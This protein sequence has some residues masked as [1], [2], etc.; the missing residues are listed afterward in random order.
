MS[1]LDEQTDLARV[2]DGLRNEFRRRLGMLRTQLTDQIE[3][4]GKAAEQR[5]RELDA[6]LDASDVRLG[7]LRGARQAIA[8]LSGEI[9]LIEG[10][11]RLEHGVVPIELDEIS[12]VLEPMVAMV[13]EAEDIRA[14]ILDDESRAALDE[15]ITAYEELER[16]AEETRTRALE[17]SRA[18]ACERAGGRAFRRAAAAYRRERERLRAQTEELRTT[19]AGCE[20]ARSALADDA[21]RQQVYRAHRGTAVVEELAVHVRDRIDA[22]VG[23]HALF[24]AW[25]TITELGHR[26]PAARAAQWRVVATQVVLYRMTYRVMHPVLALGPAPEGGHRAER[27]A[28]ILTALGRLAE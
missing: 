13:R 16:G 6:R 2:A 26:P 24:P 20:A 23:A 18:L 5:A 3:Q 21:L 1:N 15:R 27:H 25:F 14:T 9:H 7:E 22:A 28:A 17:A 11:L 4:V 19:Q 10:R 12:P 8:R